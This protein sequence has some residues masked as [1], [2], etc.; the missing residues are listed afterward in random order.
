M[1]HPAVPVLLILVV[2]VSVGC[3]AS[4]SP[5][6][7][8]SSTW[9]STPAPGEPTLDE[10]RQAL[11]RF[12]DVNVALAEGYVPDP[13][14]HCV[15]AVDVGLPAEAGAMGVHYLRMDLLQITAVEPRVDGMATHTDFLTPSVL[16]YEPQA[17]GSMELVGVENLAFTAA[18]RA[19][20]HTSP[21][22]FH[23]VAYDYM[24]DDPAT[25]LDEAHAFEPHYDRH[26]WIFRENPKGVFEQFNPAVT[27]AH[28]HGGA[29]N[30]G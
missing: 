4:A 8:G 27:C 10:L 14:N 13:D 29:H 2:L 28:H 24:A 9:A 18:W 15:T 3:N 16:L 12:R 25:E 5:D 20:G 1:K 26:V 19:A 6:E 23:G 21:P 7:T 30:G 11:D 22:S 17:D